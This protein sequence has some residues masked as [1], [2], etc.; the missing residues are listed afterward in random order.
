MPLLLQRLPENCD[1]KI[2]AHL[3]DF[4][5]RHNLD[6]MVKDF[7]KIFPSS[8]TLV[9]ERV[10]CILLDEDESKLK[11]A[12]I[13]KYLSGVDWKNCDK[14]EGMKLIKFVYLQSLIKRKFSKENK[15][16]MLL[17]LSVPGMDEIRLLHLKSMYIRGVADG[18]KFYTTFRLLTSD[19]KFACEA[20]QIETTIC[21]KCKTL[22]QVLEYAYQ[23]AVK[24]GGTNSAGI[25]LITIDLNLNFSKNI[26]LIKGKS[27]KN[28]TN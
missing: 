9:K 14:E 21:R 7:V 15:M 4:E 19:W 11:P 20:V 2:L 27:L 3:R 18:R 1:D 22:S 5:R 6:Q 8:F 12:V 16:E 28:K 10:R 17:K 13:R 26:D 25:K 23:D 24:N